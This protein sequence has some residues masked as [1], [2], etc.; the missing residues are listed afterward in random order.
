MAAAAVI[1]DSGLVL[2]SSIRIVYI[3][4]LNISAIGTCSTKKIVSLQ[5]SD[6][7]KNNILPSII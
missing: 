5:N 4:P 2:I 3:V 1:L 7:V 6:I